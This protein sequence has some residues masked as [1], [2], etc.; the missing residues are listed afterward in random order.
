MPLFRR[1]LTR[2]T[3]EMRSRP[4]SS[5]TNTFHIASPFSSRS[6]VLENC[7]APFGAVS[8]PEL[9]GSD[10]S[11]FRL[12]TF[13]IAAVE[14]LSGMAGLERRSHTYLFVTQ[15]LHF[16]RHGKPTAV[17]GSSEGS[18]EIL[19]NEEAFTGKR[20]IDWPGYC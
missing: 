16:Q 17:E 8:C 4:M 6:V 2:S 18:V 15:R 5:K 20:H 3:L 10:T 1:S 7:E 9:A 13:S 14:S 19:M 11:L 12:R